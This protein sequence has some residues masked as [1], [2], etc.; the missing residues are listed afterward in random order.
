[1]KPSELLEALAKLSNEDADI[2]WAGLNVGMMEEWDCGVEKW[3]EVGFGGP[4]LKLAANSGAYFARAH[5]E[6]K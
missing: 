6:D 5:E 3:N 2:F 4:E 1:M